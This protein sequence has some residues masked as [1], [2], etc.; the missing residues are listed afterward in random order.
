MYFRVF[1]G[2]NHPHLPVPFPHPASRSTRPSPTH[3]IHINGTT[4]PTT[5]GWY[6]GF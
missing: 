5:C 3:H 1:T 4:A 6:W 2:L